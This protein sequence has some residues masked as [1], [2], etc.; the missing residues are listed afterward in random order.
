[1]SESHRFQKDTVGELFARM[2]REAPVHYCKESRFGPYWSVTR[3][4][5]ILAIERDPE[6]YSSASGFSIVDVGDELGRSMMRSDPPENLKKR[7]PVEQMMTSSGVGDLESLAK[8]RVKKVLDGLPQEKVFDWA[9]TVSQSLTIEMLVTML[10]IPM[11]MTSLLQEWGSMASILPAKGEVVETLQ[12]YNERLS[13]CYG[14][15]LNEWKLRKKST[16]SFDFISMLAHDPTAREWSDEDFLANLLVLIIAGNDTTRHSITAGVLFLDQNPEQREL[17]YANP[18]LVKRAVSEII[19]YQTP[20]THMRRTVTRDTTLNGVKLHKG[21]KVIL[22]YLSANFDESEFDNP[23][24]F[25]ITRED[26][27]RHLSFGA[28]PHQCIGKHVAEM[29]LRVLWEELISRNLY[30]HVIGSP[31]RT[32]SPVFHGFTSLPVEIRHQ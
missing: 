6:L 3:Y 1:M 14:Y 7:R 29:Q 18:C 21:D 26:H 16:K 2:R 22:W 9:T 25:L 15:F 13:G 30:V 4:Q 5:D 17:L 31:V 20:L 12:E 23:T 28:G 32:D 11:G 24:Q 10:G 8:E 19:R 27:T